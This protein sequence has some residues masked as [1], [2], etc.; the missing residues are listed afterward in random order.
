[1]SLETIY[2]IVRNLNEKTISV[3]QKAANELISAFVHLINE[4]FKVPLE[5]MNVKFV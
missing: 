1:M 4:V 3:M 5:K 2:K